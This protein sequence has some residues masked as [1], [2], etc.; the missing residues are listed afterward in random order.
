[1]PRSLTRVKPLRQVLTAAERDV[2]V[3]LVRLII[4]CEDL[5]L[6][7]AGL[8]LPPDKAF[9]E[10]SKHYRQ[11]YFI[12]MAFSTINEMPN[13]IQKLQMIRG[14]KDKK[15]SWDRQR[16]KGWTAA[17]RFFSNTHA[18]I[19]SQRNAYG[20]HVHDDVAEHILSLVDQTDDS[21]G[22][23]EVKFSDDHSNHIVF[24][25][26][27]TL[28]SSG[29]FVHRGQRDRSEYLQESWGILMGAVRH[30]ADVVQL[31]ADLYILPTFGWG[32]TR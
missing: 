14:F 30:G 21:P 15:R 13:G 12:R 25:F 6:E 22:A 8:H 7:V 27:E 32:T 3:Q 10:V 28:V 31:L 11:M 9:D 4:L 17:V 5:K 16:L 2:M 20:G 29:F 23:L 1:M 24:K 19:D 26:A 18:F